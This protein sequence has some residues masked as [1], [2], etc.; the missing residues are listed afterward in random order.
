[1]SERISNS[2]QIQVE[3]KESLLA[4][5]QHPRFDLFLFPLQANNQFNFRGS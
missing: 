5:E 1:M 3:P 4:L 2:N